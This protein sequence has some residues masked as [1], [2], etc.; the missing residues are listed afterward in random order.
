MDDY[1]LIILKQRLI[2]SAAILFPLVYILYRKYSQS[3][4]EIPEI[5]KKKQLYA[6]NDIIANGEMS[7]VSK[8]PTS[9]SLSPSQ[10]IVVESTS[11][12]LHQVAGHTCEILR[13]FHF[14]ILKPMV[15]PKLFLREVE[16]YEEMHILGSH[17]TQVARA[18]VPKYYGV[19][20]ISNGDGDRPY[21]VLK[22]LT[23]LYLKPCVIDIKMGTQTYEP[24][25]SIEKKS[26]EHIKYSYQ[27]S[28]GFRI[29]GFKVYDTTKGMFYSIDKS[30]GRSLKPE[31]VK[32]GLKLFFHNGRI[33]RR[34]ILMAVLQR[35]ENILTWFRSQAKLHFY[36][37]SILVVFD[38]YM[39]H[40]QHQHHHSSSS[41]SF[42]SPF[43]YCPNYLEF[44]NVIKDQRGSFSRGNSIE[45]GTLN[46]KNSSDVQDKYYV[47]GTGLK[48]DQT[49]VTLSTPIPADRSQGQPPRRPFS[50]EDIVQV[51]MIDFAH[52]LPSTETT[53]IALIDEGYI[54]GIVNLIAFIRSIVQDIDSG[55]KYDGV[56]EHLGS[57]LQKS[58]SVSL[59]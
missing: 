20:N 9:S 22:D 5:E 29:T 33:F 16:L 18:F 50:Y 7:K 53:P 40:H 14:K 48:S 35:L 3:D 44:F 45:R 28:I 38:G 54:I 42:N 47:K 1:E 41:S 6:I 15:K 57:I 19:M 55:V 30:F 59:E 39:D 43:T 12:F 25:A 23:I 4:V 49:K 52:T 11:D 37:S 8:V 17:C 46:G 34:D 58:M 2:Q 13:K 24:S 26:R 51:R 21:L 10:S 27:K 56:P 32:D 31:Q 36:C